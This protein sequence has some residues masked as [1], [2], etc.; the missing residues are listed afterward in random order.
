MGDGGPNPTDANACTSMCSGMCADLKTD[1]ANCGKCGNACAMGATC[2]Q[3]SCQ[4]GAAQTKCGAT[5]VDLKTDLANC[6]KCG[7]VCG[8]GDAGMIMG[9]GTWGCVSGACTIMCPAP[10]SE[11]NGA[12]V[13]TKTDFDNCGMCNTACMMGETCTGGICCVMGQTNCGG[14]CTD[15]QFDA[16]NCSMCGKTCPMN[17]PYC[18]KGVCTQCDNTVLLLADG[19]SGPNGTFQTKAN[20]AGLSVTLV[21]NGVTTYSGNPS[22]SNFAVTMVMVG[23]AYTTDMPGAGQSAITSAQ[24]SGRGF[25]VTDWGGYHVSNGRWATLKSINLATYTTGATGSLAFTLTQSNHALWTGLPNSFTGTSSQGCQ[26]G[27]IT[28]SGVSIA[29]I[30]GPCSGPG[31]VVRTTPG[32][33]IVYLAH[34]ASYAANTTWVNDTNMVNLT[35]NALKWATGCLL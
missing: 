12:C 22:A 24:G 32:G 34:A 15:T 4:C 14:M 20:Q 3:G 2:V 30:S 10:K 19:N 28:N 7:T 5:C 11:C 13:D 35:I 23:D 31:V 21:N 6:G 33:R 1:N 17:T 26:V 25:V 9:G 29:N 8:G 16:K 18:N 27:S